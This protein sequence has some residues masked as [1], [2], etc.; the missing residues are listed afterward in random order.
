[1]NVM[2]LYYDLHI[3]SDVSDGKLTRKEIIGIAEQK[4]I[5]YLN[6]LKESLMGI[7]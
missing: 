4:N 2:K 1:M 6:K 5:D 3:H 7:K